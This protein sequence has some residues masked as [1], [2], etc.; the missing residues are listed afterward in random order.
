MTGSRADGALAGVVRGDDTGGVLITGMR[1][2]GWSVRLVR[3]AD[4]AGVLMTGRREV[5]PA[6]TAAR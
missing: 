6:D 4:V 2:A 1:P 3:G 5:R